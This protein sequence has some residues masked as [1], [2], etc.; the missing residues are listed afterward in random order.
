LELLTP[1]PLDLNLAMQS[2]RAARSA[3]LFQGKL[4]RGLLS[5]FCRCVIL[6]FALIASKS[7]EFPHN[8]TSLSNRLLNNFSYNS[9]AHGPSALAN[10]E[11]ESLVHGHR[12]D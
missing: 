5:V 7:D 12:R 9:G 6:T 11:L 1:L 3:K 4:F 2:M 10:G 8:A